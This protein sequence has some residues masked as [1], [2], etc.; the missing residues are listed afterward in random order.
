MKITLPT[1]LLTIYSTVC[2]HAQEPVLPETVQQ[3]I[4]NAVQEVN[5]EEAATLFDNYSEYLE[6]PLDINNATAAEL[7][8]F[9]LLND[10]QVQSLL[11]Y[12]SN[13]GALFS[14]H[15][16]ALIH[17]FNEQ[18][19][20]QLSPFF[21]IQEF[22]T[23][24]NEK[25]WNRFSGGK[26]E[27]MMR[28]SHTL[29]TRKGYIKD[30]VG[31]QDFVPLDNKHYLGFPWS[32][33]LRYR[34]THR[35]NLQWGFTATNGAGEAFF[36]D[37]N[38]YGFDFYSFHIVV[39]DVSKHI[40]R[41]VLGDYQT[42]FGQGLVL[43]TGAMT[44]KSANVLGAKKQER[45]FTAHTGSDENRFFRGLGTSLEWAGWSL[46]AFL[47]YKFIDAAMEEGGFKTLQT[48]GLH[49]TTSTV[50]N[51][52]TLG[53][54]V[55]GGNISRT[56]RYLKVGFTGVWYYYDAENK[57]EVKPYNI[58]ELNTNQ[59]ANA[60]IDFSIPWKRCNLFGEAAIS[61]NGGM[62]AM[63][64]VVVD[65]AYE[66]RLS[67]VYRNYGIDYVAAHAKG[68][69]ENSKTMN[70][71]GWYAA[72]QWT[73]LSSLT[74]I[75]YVDAFSFPWLRYGVDA[76]SSG[77]DYHLQAAWQLT[78]ETG[79]VFQ[80]KQGSK[81]VVNQKSTSVRYGIKYEL[82]PG[83]RMEDRLDIRFF[84][85]GTRESGLS[86]YHS[87]SHKI[88]AIKLDCSARLAL[89]DTRGWNSR[90]YAYE[91]D[92]AGAFSVPA[93]AGQGIRWYINLHWQVGIFWDLWLHAAQS[94][95]SDRESIS[96]GAAAIEGKLQ[97]DIKLQ[98]RI[99]L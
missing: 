9:P 77:W 59:N 65:L 48:S 66:F 75:G 60:G 32:L 49:N 88:P 39:N 74:I 37:N 83:L 35:K 27:V 61:S 19:A 14:I 62:A 76:P 93:Y 25:I 36:K 53:E 80:I 29:E 50:A 86:L 91:S 3:I 18:I 20:Q 67:S 23:Y 5:E 42:Q 8:Q 4:E 15:E 46:S 63:I 22:A 40:K 2:A 89:F 69:G 11:D 52:H 21:T 10:F 64:G 47:S 70:E 30:E 16:L 12:R 17:G 85:N 68:F 41:V 79:M 26:H 81:S 99:K 95:Y 73:P 97:T 55:A 56:W 7:R 87:V 13:Y 51:K 54:L 98:L 92:V 38:P 84:D 43:W 28:T 96:S 58:F 31:A 72:L 90:I 45:G 82:I 33:Y 24:K 1:L 71:K 6:H 78:P 57:R 94:R 44:R 34:Y